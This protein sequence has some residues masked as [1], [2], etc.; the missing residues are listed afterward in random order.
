MRQRASKQQR[1]TPDKARVEGEN[2]A[3]EYLRSK[4]IYATPGKTSQ[5]A[6]V[7]VAAWGAVGIEVK[8]AKYDVL[9]RRFT[10]TTTP[11]QRS[12]GFSAHLVMLICEYSDRMTYHLFP[13]NHSV[14][15]IDGRMKSGIVFSLKQS[16]GSKHSGSRVVMT[17]ALMD[18]YE[19]R[20]DLIWALVM[21]ISEKLTLGDYQ[22]VAGN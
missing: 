18:E 12:Q 19:N 1:I 16:A 21:Q 3:I 20:V 22:P 17:Q 8:H 13:V 7:D 5:L 10:F 11:R 6:W 2:L 14:F 9:S 4:G 15:Y